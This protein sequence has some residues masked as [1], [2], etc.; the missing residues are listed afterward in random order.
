MAQTPKEVFKSI[1]SFKAPER[2]PT[3]VSS[4]VIDRFAAGYTIESFYH[5]S[6]EEQARFIID[7]H[8]RNGGDHLYTG[9]NGTIAVKALGGR[10]TFR[11]HGFPDVESPLI[12]SISELEKIDPAI[13]KKDFY[14]LSTYDT[15][16]ELVRQGGDH[17]GILVGSWGIFTQAGL[18]FG[19]EKLMRATRK[20]PNAVFALLD[21]TFE[22]FKQEHGDIVS[23]GADIGSIAD[24]S[25]S[26][27][28]ISKKTFETFSL[29][30]ITK[31]A[32]WYAS[33]GANTQL[34]ICGDIND[35]VDLI[36]DSGIK[37]L[38]VDYKVDIVKA[39][40]TMRG[41]AIIG[42]NADPV[43]II[44][45]ADTETNIQVY[46]D[47]I[48]ALSGEPYIIMSGCGIPATAPVANIRAINELAYNTKP[49]EYGL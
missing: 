38:S 33:F 1:L 45:D 39:A 47:T 26:G 10:V 30:Y 36:A 2:L 14:Y 19:A 18:I 17:Y 5:L 21:W 16:V 3:T 15:A 9:Y 34:H 49:A 48:E 31:V 37:I 35:R 23:L 46:A 44:N 22:L 25:A 11:D 41:K 27:D 13:I 20:D 40:K 29:P 43:A 6:G 8:D 42:G 7:S 28:M 4:D 12:E 32:D 24:P